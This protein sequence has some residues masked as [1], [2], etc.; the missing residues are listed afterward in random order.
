MIFVDV[1]LHLMYQRYRLEICPKIYTTGFLGQKFYALKVCKLW[2]FIPIYP[3]RRQNLLLTL[4]ILIHIPLS[5]SKFASDFG[6]FKSKISKNSKFRK[7]N[8][9]SRICF[10]N[11]QNQKGAVNDIKGA[12]ASLLIN[13]Q[14]F[15]F[16]LRIAIARGI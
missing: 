16:Q 6:N 4:E 11:F 10:Q 3:S 7:K 14:N 13:Y 1:F 15:H 8:P 2:L 9:K 12:A 5:A